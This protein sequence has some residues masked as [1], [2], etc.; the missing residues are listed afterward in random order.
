MEYSISGRGDG[1]GDSRQVF[2]KEHSGIVGNSLAYHNTLLVLGFKALT[3]Q[4]ELTGSSIKFCRRCI[5]RK[6]GSINLEH[7]LVL[8]DFKR[9]QEGEN[10]PMTTSLQTLKRQE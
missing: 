3:L 10:P 2:A 5:V 6:T 7:I 4:T 9:S 8:L 1:S